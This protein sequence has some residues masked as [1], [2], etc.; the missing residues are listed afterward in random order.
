MAPIG[1]R[2]ASGEAA[3]RGVGACAILGQWATVQ[4]DSLEGL[5]SPCSMKDKFVYLLGTILHYSTFLLLAHFCMINTLYQ[6][7]SVQYERL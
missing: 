6:S 3:W 7:V 5:R 2:L 4:W 1:E